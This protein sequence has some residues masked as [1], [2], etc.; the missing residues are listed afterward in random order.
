MRRTAAVFVT[1]L[2]VIVFGITAAI[3]I[4]LVRN[5][6]DPAAGRA[7][8]RFSAAIRANDGETACSLLAAQTRT[9]LE[10]QEGSRCESAI[11]EL[12]LSGGAVG[13]VDVAEAAARAEVAGDGG[14]YLDEGPD[15]WRITALGC[16]PLTGRPDDCE[17]ES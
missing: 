10:E 12:G 17:L 2:V 11:L 4:G 16:R 5:G 3:V 7:V 1:Y 14:A 8:E 6:D 9:A 15:G 13:R